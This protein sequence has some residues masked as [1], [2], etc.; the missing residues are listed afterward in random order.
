LISFKNILERNIKKQKHLWWCEGAFAEGPPPPPR[1]NE[2]TRKRF[3]KVREQ[4]VK[5]WFEFELS[6]KDY[7]I[8]PIMDIIETV[9]VITTLH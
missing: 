7:H 3:L 5:E 6:I 1:P 4:P 2:K 9:V 8:F